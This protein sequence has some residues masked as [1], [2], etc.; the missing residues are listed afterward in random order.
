MNYGEQEGRW[1]TLE[2][3]RY[4][5]GEISYNDVMHLKLIVIP[6]Q[7]DSTH[8]SPCKF[9]NKALKTGASQEAGK[10]II[11]TSHLGLLQAD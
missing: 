1:T 2:G 7:Q 10:C 4:R 9:V 5:N 8:S 6:K 11:N 3:G